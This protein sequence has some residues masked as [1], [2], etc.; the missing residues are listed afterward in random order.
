MLSNLSFSWPFVI[1]I[2]TSLVSL[3][4]LID[5]LLKNK[6][7]AALHG[8]F[9]RL[10]KALRETS[11]REWQVSTAGVGVRFLDN[12]NDKTEDAISL[13][14][15]WFFNLNKPGSSDWVSRGVF[16]GMLGSFAFVP[17]LYFF[18]SWW[19][20]GA[21]AFPFVVFLLV[22]GLWFFVVSETSKLGPF[23]D[24]LFPL[25]LSLTWISATLSLLATFIVIYAVP[26][27]L[28]NTYW[29]TIASESIRPTAPLLL[30]TINFPLDL[31]TILITVS[32]LKFIQRR[33]RFILLVAFADIVIS[34]LLSIVLY[35]ILKG[36]EHGWDVMG[37]WTYTQQSAMW[38]YDLGFYFVASLLKL[39]TTVDITAMPDLHLAPILLTTLVP[40]SLYMSVFIFLS[41][42]KPVMNFAAR[43][44]EAVGERD[45][46]V[47]AQFGT[48]LASILA[49]VKAVVAYLAA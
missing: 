41:F 10:A 5:F 11:L 2:C 7:V 27:S 31:A 25:I 6:E 28:L 8:R 40:V 38:F 17:T 37:I 15:G 46:S 30:P 18:T 9:L 20:A 4:G 42:A 47:F 32:L 29:F 43:V 36:V 22:V 16:F 19:I 1:A 24:V 3:G 39:P 48:L 45:K 12:L 23:E 13:P 21:M 33:G 34:L 14:V 35:T 44:F 49:A 26:S